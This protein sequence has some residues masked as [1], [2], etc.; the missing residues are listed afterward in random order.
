M[1][2]PNFDFVESAPKR[3]LQNNCCPISAQ[4]VEDTGLFRRT[5]RITNRLQLYIA[6]SEFSL[7]IMDTVKLAYT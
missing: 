6:I 7:I 1:L 4:T 2:W 5:K 3:K